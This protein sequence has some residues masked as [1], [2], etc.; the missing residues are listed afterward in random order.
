[1][2]FSNEKGTKNT[3]TWD[4]F[5]VVY[6]MQNKIAIKP[7]A[8]VSFY[9]STYLPFHSFTFHEGMK[10]PSNIETAV[11][12]T[13]NRMNKIIHRKSMISHFQCYWKLGWNYHNG[14]VYPH[15]HHCIIS[16][17]SSSNYHSIIS[18]L[19]KIWHWNL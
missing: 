1:M 9:A 17:S 8:F 18:T 12:V 14:I 16:S 6:T 5:L 3:N 15:H 11:L 4:T 19:E 10:P 13:A 7:L 2:V